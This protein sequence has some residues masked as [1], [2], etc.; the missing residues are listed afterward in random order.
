MSEDNPG[1]RTIDPILESLVAA[2]D[3]QER[4]RLIEALIFRAHGV[5]NRVLKSAGGALTHEDT[6]DIISLVT[7]RL[8]RR[9]ERLD[10]QEPIASFDD[11][12]ARL[13]F[14]SFYD[15]LRR[16]H[17]ERS[18]LKNRLRYLFT[19]DERLKLWRVANEMVAGLSKWNNRSDALSHPSLDAGEASQ[20]MLDRTSPADAVI[21]IF[22]HLA[23]PLVFESLVT[24]IAR[25]WDVR[26]EGS[27]GSHAFLSSQMNE[28]ESRDTLEKLWEE[29]LLLRP[30]Q[31]AALLLNLRDSEGRN[32]IALLILLG[33]TNIEELARAVGIERTALAELWPRLPI[34]DLEIA[35]MF[36]L[37]RQQVINL[38]K[39]ARE[40]LVRRL[41]MLEKG[42]NKRI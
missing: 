3:E 15:F 25:L 20:A 24:L 28:V 21:A 8:L 42:T 36:A 32:A 12:V 29:I 30:L 41:A 38:R 35:S 2:V 33:I 6:E 16:R 13:T 31:R 23:R 27:A 26:E 39:A 7:L 9:I 10:D 18:R 4:E 17:P 5:A 1:G 19:H 40:R 37:T 22:K 11:F 34:S 14:N